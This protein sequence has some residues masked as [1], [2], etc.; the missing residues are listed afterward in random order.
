MAALVIYFICGL[1]NNSA[2]GM[3]QTRTVCRMESWWTL[4]QRCIRATLQL[5]ETRT[6]LHKRNC[7]KSSY[8]RMNRKT[9][10]FVERYQRFGKLLLPPSQKRRNVRTS[11]R[12]YQ[13]TAQTFRKSISHLNI[14]DA[15]RVTWSKYYREDPQTYGATLQNLIATSTWRPA[16]LY[17][18][19]TQAPRT[20]N[21][22]LLHIP[23]Y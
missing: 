15:K 8:R 12:I 16:F 22:V 11:V 6:P 13:S 2:Q 14:L 7:I 18:C 9:T 19:S 4:L 1:I 3:R 21:V 5:R 10:R 20:K 17:P 23:G